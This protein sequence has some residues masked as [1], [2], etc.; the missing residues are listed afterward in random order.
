MLDGS[1]ACTCCL[2]SALVC[3]V[4]RASFSLYKQDF[5]G[6]FIWILPQRL[7]VYWTL[8][9]L[10]H[11]QLNRSLHQCGDGPVCWI[12]MGSWVRGVFPQLLWVCV[13]GR[14]WPG[15]W[16]C[17]NVLQ[18]FKTWCHFSSLSLRPDLSWC[19]LSPSS[20]HWKWVRWKQEQRL[21]KES[22]FNLFHSSSPCN[23]QSLSLG[24][25]FFNSRSTVWT[26]LKW[27]TSSEK[28]HL[29]YSSTPG[30]V[31]YSEICNKHNVLFKYWTFIVIEVLAPYESSIWRSSLRSIM[32]KF[33]SG[34]VMIH[35]FVDF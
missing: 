2:L 17:M 34:L 7:F 21:K 19:K 24:Q 29:R 6:I 16:R 30:H 31:L 35:V 26:P 14:Q 10:I 12:W 13:S 20:L 5:P 11:A 33:A 3:V 32:S 27:C 28:I 1:S 9:K 8:S 4:H 18:T 25:G 22:L 23:T 15:R